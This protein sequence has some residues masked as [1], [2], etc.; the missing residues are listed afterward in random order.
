MLTYV[1]SCLISS[2]QHKLNLPA[3]ILQD[4]MH[5]GFF[6][7]CVLGGFRFSVSVVDSFYCWLSFWMK[8]GGEEDGSWCMY[9]CIVT[10]NEYWSSCNCHRY[11][12]WIRILLNLDSAYWLTWPESEHELWGIPG[13]WRLSFDDGRP[14]KG[15]DLCGSLSSAARHFRRWVFPAI[16]RQHSRW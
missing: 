7:E 12:L 13:V 3:H 11:V 10:E 1:C 2:A 5:N 14:D 16:P 8:D 4:H 15:A 9:R 6:Y